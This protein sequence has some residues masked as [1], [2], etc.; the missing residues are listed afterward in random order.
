LGE[1]SIN[2]GGMHVGRKASGGE[3][4]MVLNVDHPVSEETLGRLTS[5]SGVIKAKM[6]KL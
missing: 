2:I 1:D 6:I 5:V 3:Q 4:I